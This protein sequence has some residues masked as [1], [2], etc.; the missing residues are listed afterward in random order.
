[1][2]KRKRTPT[3]RVLKKL[4]KRS[5]GRPRIRR[6]KVDVKSSQGNSISNADKMQIVLLAKDGASPSE[7]AG[8]VG[9]NY[10]TAVNPLSHRF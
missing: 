5:V 4:S 10:K 7:I 6:P 1:M 9:C 8:I 3:K 2:G